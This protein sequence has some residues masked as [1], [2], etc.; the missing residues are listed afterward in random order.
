MLTIISCH[1]LMISILLG[2]STFVSAQMTCT[3]F[4]NYTYSSDGPSA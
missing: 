1:F 3:K 2:L 4:G